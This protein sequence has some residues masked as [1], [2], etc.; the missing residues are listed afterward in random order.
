LTQVIS[1][2]LQN[3]AKF[4]RQAGRIWISSR[5]EADEAVI[6][7]RDAGAGI[8]AGLLPRVFDLFA[9]GDR[10]LER[11][12]GGLGIGLTVVRRLVEMHGGRVSAHSAGPDKGSEFV[13]RLPIGRV[14]D[15][16]RPA[17]GPPGGLGA[18]PRDVLVVDDN[19]DA[20]HSTAMLL[21]AWGHRVRVAYSGQEALEAAEQAVPEVVL[22]DIGLPLING[23]DVAR[24]LREQE[25]YANTVLAAV[26]GYGQA[27][28]RRRSSEVGFDFH[29]TK[30]VDAVAL[31]EVVSTAGRRAM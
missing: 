28:D 16:S 26:T 30:P 24:R 10:T 11:S 9:Q 13:V 4:S 18:A 29:L 20:A 6:R 19:V 3:A 31:Q 25:R 1:N 5:R 12:Q 27:E 14:A 15:E 7:V 21:R 17:P 23:Y 8:P 22:L 2:L